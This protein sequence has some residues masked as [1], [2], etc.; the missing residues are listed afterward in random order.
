MAIQRR[1]DTEVR[2][3]A[4]WRPKLNVTVSHSAETTLSQVE[5]WRRREISDAELAGIPDEEASIVLLRRK[6][7]GDVLYTNHEGWTSSTWPPRNLV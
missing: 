1:S 4:Q 3:E 6:D 7:N 2:V 5:R